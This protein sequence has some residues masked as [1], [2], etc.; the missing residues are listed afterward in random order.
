MYFESKKA[1]DLREFGFSK[2]CKFNEVQIVLSLLTDQNG[3]PLSYELF[4]GNMYEGHTMLSCL[5]SLKEKYGLQKAIVVADR[6][7][8]SAANLA[9]IAKMG[10]EYIVGTKLKSSNA[11]IKNA[12]FDFE[13][14]QQRR[15][16]ELGEFK[17]KKIINKSR[18]N[19]QENIVVA[20]SNKRAKKDMQDRMKLDDKAI[21]LAEYGNVIDKRG[22][23]K[24]LKMTKTSAELDATKI[25]ED[26]RWD[27]YYGI[28]T[29]SNLSSEEIISA[30]HNLWKIEDSFRLMKSH[31]ETRPMFHWTAKRISGHIM[32]NFMAMI[33]ER[34]IEDKVNQEVSEQ[35]KKISP[36]KIRQAV[37]SM[38]KSVLMIDGKRFNS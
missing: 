32:L 29:N 11:S 22:G 34:Y 17:H 27:G 12:V 31:F 25:A 18:D 13:G 8:Y 9:T 24:Y 37:L 1:D 30:Y 10:F 14:Y 19:H 16:D 23:K 36:S 2:D 5:K 33:F 6:G 28:S 15:D 26:A 20:W 7:M 35:E 3:R 38:Q 21:R 4:K